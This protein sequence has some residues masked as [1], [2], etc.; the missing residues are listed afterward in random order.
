M[1]SDDE[2]PSIGIDHPTTDVYENQDL[3]TIQGVVRYDEEKD[4]YELLALEYDGH[5]IDGKLAMMTYEKDLDILYQDVEGNSALDNN[6]VTW[7][8]VTDQLD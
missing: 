8:E 6:E 1:S 2:Q 5:P 7:E 4:R 3:E